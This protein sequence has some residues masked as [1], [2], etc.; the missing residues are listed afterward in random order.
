MACEQDSNAAAE[1]IIDP[2]TLADRHSRQEYV[3]QQWDR[4]TFKD[5]FIFQKTLQSNHDL[6]LEICEIII[7]RKIHRI[8]FPEAEKSINMRRRNRSIRLDVYLKA[9]S[10]SSIVLE[11]QAVNRGHLPRRIR[12]YQGLVDLDWLEK[13]Q[14]FSMLH[15]SLIAF[16]CDFDPFGLG[17]PVYTFH[18]TCDEAPHLKLEDGVTKMFLNAKSMGETLPDKLK[19]F[20]GYVAKGVV[21]DDFTQRLDEAVQRIKR[22]EDWRLEYMSYEMEI[23]E[24]EWEAAERAR[25]AAEKAAEKVAEKAIAEAKE[26]AAKAKKEAEEIKEAAAKAKNEARENIT[27]E[28]LKNLMRNMNTSAEK[29][30]EALSIPVASRGFYLDMLRA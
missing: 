8:T 28:L 2:L 26:A 16:I 12:Y 9:D 21:G 30:M 3:R 25:K 14:P 18:T 13:G 15:N 17:L 7:G 19:A 5:N 6:C 29:A 4:L 22:D 23:L 20:L 10:D 27:L 11:M 24:R 1:V